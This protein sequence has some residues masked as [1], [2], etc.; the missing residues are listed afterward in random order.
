MREINLR[1]HQWSCEP[2]PLTIGERDALRQALPLAIA[3]A[4]G[5]DSS[6]FLRPNSTIG[7]VEVG[8]LSVLVKP[9]AGIPQV[10]SLACYAIGKVKFQRE[11]FD[12]REDLTLPEAL[13]VALT[14]QARETFARGLLHGYRAEEDALYTVRGRIRFDEQLRRRFGRSLPVEVSFDEFTADVLPNQL[15]KAATLRLGQA[16]LRSAE[17]RRNL[18]W[19]ASTLDEVSP[20]EFFWSQVPEVRYDRLN[21]HYRGVVELSRLVLRHGAFDSGRGDIRASGFL[22]DMND[23]FQEFVTQALR[24]VPDIPSLMF[25]ERV[26]DTLDEEAGVRLRP[27]L[28]GWRDS[29]CVF[30]GDV[31]YKN[32]TNMRVP[33]GDIYQM[34]AYAIASDQPGGMLIYAEGEAQVGT[35]RIRHAGKRLEVVALDIAGPLDEVLDRVRRLAAKISALASVER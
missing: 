10:L 34:L 9:K 17:A 35:Y 13:A 27:D 8:D 25:R 16:P 28:T 12:Y 19:L 29:R 4:P 31:K 1:E 11:D 33:A 14:R 30:V 22:M 3:P 20:V 5:S 24:E 26:I 21:E 32:L 18:G 2:H 15:V 23:T 6:Y 7:A